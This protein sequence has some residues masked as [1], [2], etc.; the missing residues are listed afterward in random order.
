[1]ET[2]QKAPK[3][4]KMAETLAANGQQN[5]VLSLRRKTR[6]LSLKTYSV[7]MTRFGL[8]VRDNT[9]KAGAP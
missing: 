8:G 6:T 1:M 2:Q 4:I 5:I 3:S 9:S 7:S